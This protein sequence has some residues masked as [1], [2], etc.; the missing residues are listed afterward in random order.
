MA[1]T[2]EYAHF[3]KLGNKNVLNDGHNKVYSISS[4]QRD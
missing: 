3:H 4:H 1:I 2:I